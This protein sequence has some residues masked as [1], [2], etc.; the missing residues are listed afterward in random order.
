MVGME[1]SS[2]TEVAEPEGGFEFYDETA[3]WIAKRL[4]VD[5]DELVEASQT[6][7]NNPIL[8]EGYEGTPEEYRVLL[9]ERG[10]ENLPHAIV[11]ANK[12]TEELNNGVS[13]E[14]KPYLSQAREA[15]VDYMDDELQASGST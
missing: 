6:Y 3:E 14:A 4:G 11:F 10:F 13:P 2:K 7:G 12:A 15:A 8:K 1:V 5:I 9:K